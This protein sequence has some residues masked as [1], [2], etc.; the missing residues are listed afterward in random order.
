MTAFQA[1]AEAPSAGQAGHICSSTGPLGQSR[2]LVRSVDA[3]ID[4]AL[5]VTPG[6]TPGKTVKAP[7]TKAEAEVC[8]GVLLD[9]VYLNEIGGSTSY[10]LGQPATL[11]ED[12][13]MWVNSEGT[14]AFGDPVFVRILTDGGSNTTKGTLTNVSDYPSGGVVITPDASFTAALTTVGLTLSDGTN[15]Q[16]FQFSTDASPTTAEVAAGL[17]AAIDASDFFAATGSV[18]ISVTST[19]GIVEVVNLDERLTLTTPAR[20]HRRPGWRWA[21]ARTGAGLTKLQVQPKR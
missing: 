1:F 19:S 2:T 13:Y 18:T 16:T 12:G 9:P 7:T 11:L 14:V 17:V 15:T 6:A 8:E 4:C 20:A 3:A 21:K 5:A 10:T